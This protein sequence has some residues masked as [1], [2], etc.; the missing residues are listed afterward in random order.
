MLRQ[1]MLEE[2]GEAFPYL[3]VEAPDHR[4][5]EEDEGSARRVLV[6]LFLT[7]TEAVVAHRNRAISRGRLGDDIRDLRPAQL[8]IGL[9]GVAAIEHN[10]RVSRNA[11]GGE[12]QDAKQNLSDAQ[13]RGHDEAENEHATQERDNRGHAHDQGLSADRAELRGLAKHEVR[14]AD[15]TETAQLDDVACGGTCIKMNMT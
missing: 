2:I 1:L 7:Q 12:I 3:R 14:C 5:A 4:I 11:K 9:N 10:T 8:G 15:R 13:H 6:E